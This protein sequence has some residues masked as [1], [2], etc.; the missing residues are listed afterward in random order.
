MK[1]IDFH[2]HIFPDKMAQKTIAFLSQKGGIPAYTDATLSALNTQ[3][4][5]AKGAFAVALPVLT[6]PQSFESVLAFVQNVN[7]G[8]FK[9]EHNVF[10]FGGIHPDCEDIEEKMSRMK[11]LGIKGVKLHPE[12]QQT[13]ID[14]KKYIRIFKAA[15]KEDMI[16]ITHSGKDVGYPND[17]HCTPKR[18]LNALEKTQ[19]KVK[20]V[21]AH[22]GACDMYDEVLQYLA[23]QDVYFD[24]AHVLASVE[25]STFI[26]ILEKH[27]EEKILFA[28]DCPW[29][30]ITESK[31]KLISFGL[32]EETTEK[33]FYKNALGLLNDTRFNGLYL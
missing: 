23:G 18:V 29:Q 30:D 6:K 25:Q 22:L 32:S 28:S 24:T 20:L 8:F 10:S 3:V 5:K 12:Y 15:A 9:G 33:I 13:Y 27:G 31:E 11:S 4:K 19:E 7:E 1:L 2:T 17:V 26:K 16:V 21:L 14:D